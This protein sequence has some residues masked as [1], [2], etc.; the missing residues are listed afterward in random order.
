MLTVVIRDAT[1]LRQAEQSRIVQIAA[2]ASNRA[3]TDFLS[4][5]SHELRTPLNA[6]LGFSQLLQSDGDAPLT[7][8][9][10]RQ[11]EH[12]RKAGWNLLALINDVLDVSKIEAGAIEVEERRVDVCEVLDA[13][14]SHLEVRA[15][16]GR[17]ARFGD[18]GRRTSASTG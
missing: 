13:G 16:R 18:D 8:G 11:V 4:R 12:I 10:N 9:Q 1:E 2:E 17:H 14:D 7:E 3:K 15:G 5:M 6:V